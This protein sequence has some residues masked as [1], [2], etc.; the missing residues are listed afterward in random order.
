MNKKNWPNFLC[1]VQK[2]V[3]STALAISRLF[4]NTRLTWL[5]Q[6]LNSKYAAALSVMGD[7]VNQW[8]AAKVID[9]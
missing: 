1:T 8:V 3:E 9:R 7:I 6:I 5:I 2:L 4:T